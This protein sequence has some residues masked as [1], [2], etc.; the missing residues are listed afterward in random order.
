MCQNSGT[1]LLALLLTAHLASSSLLLTAH[2]AS[3]SLIS[4]SSAP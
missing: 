4:A 1:F 3:S 2:L